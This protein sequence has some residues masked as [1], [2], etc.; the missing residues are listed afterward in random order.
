[1]SCLAISEL[2]AVDQMRIMRAR[3]EETMRWVDTLLPVTEP[4][5]LDG[6]AT[7]GATVTGAF[8]MESIA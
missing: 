3:I 7:P 6:G 2:P 4:S 1:M 8:H 5:P